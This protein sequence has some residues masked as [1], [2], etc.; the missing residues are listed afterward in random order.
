M[1]RLA[2]FKPLGPFLGL[3]LIA[4]LLAGI[5]TT[6]IA[7]SR[8]PIPS[9][10]EAS[11]SKKRKRPSNRGNLTAHIA[12]RNLAGTK[13]SE[14]PVAAATTPT[15]EVDDGDL[16]K[17]SINGYVLAVVR[18]ENKN[19]SVAQI[20]NGLQ[21]KSYIGYI[22][23]RMWPGE[24]AGADLFE[25][26]DIEADRVIIRELSNNK[27]SYLERKE[28]KGG[29]TASPS[30]GKSSKGGSKSGKRSEVTKEIVKGIKSSGNNRWE[31]E[32][33]SIDTVLNNLSV[34]SQDARVVPD[35]SGGKQRGFKLF[36]IKPGS[37][38][39]KIGVR[40]G[41]ILTSVNG[42]GL[43]SPDKILEVYGKLKDS[44]QITVEILRRGKPLSLEY[45]IR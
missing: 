17:S 39:S 22:G 36:S 16:V 41:D 33:K 24:E 1:D 23:D 35:F 20:E 45:S 40:N 42:Y 44:S 19:H 38:Y 4:Y 11:K 30:T 25:I 29:P 10:P 2:R 34:L 9:V 5:V 28:Q 12:E 37:V 8:M 27:R 43:D 3:A 6:F 31:V 14:Q 13:R 32:Q 15:E 7:D 26:L 18:F 21:R